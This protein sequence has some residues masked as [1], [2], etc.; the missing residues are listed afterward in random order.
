MI[1]EPFEQ[2][3]LSTASDFGDSTVHPLFRHPAR[4][5]AATAVRQRIPKS[6]AAREMGGGMKITA[7][8]TIHVGAYPNITWVE[9]HTDAGLVGLGETFWGPRAVA[10]HV[11]EG[12][13]PLLLGQDPLAI[14]AHRHWLLERRM[15]GLRSSG[16][17]MRAA[18]GGRHRAVGSVRAKRTRPA[19]LAAPRRADPRARAGLQHLRRLP[20]NQAGGRRLVTAGSPAR[21]RGTLRRSGRVH[22]AARRAGGEPAGEG[23]HRDEDLAVRPVRP[24]P[25]R[26]YISARRSQARA[27][28]LPPDP[29]SGRRPD[30]RPVRAALDL[31]PAR[32]GRGSAGRWR[33]TG[34]SGP[35]TR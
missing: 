22:A 28:A 30:G 8:E 15:R 35:R 9:V 20:Y 23:Y 34:R 14:E 12:I 26:R 17:E 2:R 5:R 11:H 7:V 18:L 21:R 24:R 13:A 32:R 1:R 16:A 4:I 31:E 29:R 25:R 10:A 3:Y 33:S 6:R 27:R 19:G